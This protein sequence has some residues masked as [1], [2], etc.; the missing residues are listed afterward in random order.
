MPSACRGD[1]T[2]AGTRAERETIARGERY[3]FARGVE[4]PIVGDPVTRGVEGD[5][6]ADLTFWSFTNSNVVASF[7]SGG[8]SF[9]TYNI[10]S[11]NSLTCS[12][13][14]G[15]SLSVFIVVDNCWILLW[16]PAISI[17]MSSWNLCCTSMSARKLCSAWRSCFFLLIFASRF[18][19]RSC[20]VRSTAAS[21]F[22]CLCSDWVCAWV[23]VCV[24]LSACV[25]LG[26]FSA[27][28]VLCDSFRF[29]LW[30]TACWVDQIEMQWHVRRAPWTSVQS[31]STWKNLISVPF[32]LEAGAPNS[33]GPVQVRT[34]DTRRRD[35]SA[36]I[37][38]CFARTAF[39]VRLCALPTWI[40]WPFVPAFTGRRSIRRSSENFTQAGSIKV[41]EGGSQI[42]QQPYAQ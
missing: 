42:L 27:G 30:L 40:F 12:S 17:F 9:T 5:M 37:V 19:L 23:S 41:V 15:I 6:S 1:G 34:L 33:V 39:C 16:R 11:A 35:S 3:A 13:M 14:P 4:D 36:T 38:V 20:L 28:V 7:G 26:F 2:R 18:F 10:S 31:W 32:V 21:V 25:T 22:C 24:W 8:G 29:C